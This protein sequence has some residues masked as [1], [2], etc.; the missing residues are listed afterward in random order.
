MGDCDNL[1]PPWA[2]TAMPAASHARKVLRTRRRHD[3]R[4]PAVNRSLADEFARMANAQ[5]DRGARRVWR[6]GVRRVLRYGPLMLVDLAARISSE[7][8]AT[9]WAKVIALAARN[10]VEALHAQGAFS[11]EQAP[12][13]NRR[14]RGR[15]YEVLIAIRRMDASRDEDQFTAYVLDLIDDWEQ[16]PLRAALGRAIANAVWE[17]ADAAEIDAQTAAQLEEAAVAGA[18]EVVELYYRLDHQQ[19]RRQLAFLMIS[20]PSYWERPQPS[21]SFEAMLKGRP[22]RRPSRAG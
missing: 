7:E 5:N 9:L 17:F 19:A 4:V 1:D 14:L 18:L 16:D 22:A 8:H 21:P 11:D 13:L 2:S 3:A 10:G 6:Q 20:I 15:A 12:A